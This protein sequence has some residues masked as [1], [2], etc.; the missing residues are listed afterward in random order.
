VGITFL[1]L[2]FL[3]SYFL[4]ATGFLIVLL[5]SDTFYLVSLTTGLAKTIALPTT[6]RDLL[7][8]FDLE[9]A[10]AGLA[11]LRGV[12]E[13]LIGETDAYLAT[14]FFS[15]SAYFL[16]ALDSR[17]LLGITAGFS[18]VTGLGSSVW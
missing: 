6:A 3:S 2:L 8:R 1:A 10:A 4:A 13:R 16:E 15:F 5:F 9:A 14:G 12:S 7:A 17:F 11:W 18:S